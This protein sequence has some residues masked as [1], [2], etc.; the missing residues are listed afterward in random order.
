MCCG[1]L[2]IGAPRSSLRSV[3]LTTTA[4][5]IT[6]LATPALAQVTVTGN[7]TPD[8]WAPA[9][10]LVIGDTSFG[11]VTVENGST[12][13]SSSGSLGELADSDG[14]AIITG[15][16][17]RWDITNS[18]TVGNRGAATLQV[19][20]GGVVTTGDWMDI[21]Y[22][23]DSEAA[24]YVSGVDAFGNAST[25]QVGEE[26]SVGYY[27]G[28]SSAMLWVTDGGKVISSGGQIGYGASISTFGTGHV[29]V[30]GSDGGDN[31][32]TWEITGELAVGADVYGT[33]YLDITEGGKVVSGSGVLG[34][35]EFARGEVVVAGNDGAGNVSTWEI[36][37]N[38]TVG[39]DHVGKLD[40]TGG[41]KVTSNLVD[42]AS[43]SSGEGAITVTGHGGGAA[44]T[45][46]VNSQLRVGVKGEGQL[47]VE[48]GGRVESDFG[49]IAYETGSTGEVTISGSDGAGN[50]SIWQ[51]NNTL[52]IGRRG[53]GEVTVTEGGIIATWDVSAMVLGASLGG[54]GN[55]TLNIGAKS[56]AGA[57]A[58]GEVRTGELRFEN[59]DA[60]LVF[61]HTD[62]IEFST[63]MASGGVGNHTLKHEAGITTITG[64]NV[65][66]T[67]TTDVSGGTLIVGL[68]G[69]GSLVGSDVSVG[70]AGTLKGT[71]AL[72]RLTVQSGGLHA[73]GNSI[74]TQDVNGPYILQ[75]GAILEIEI[76][77]SSS[78]VVVVNGTVDI[79]GAI[80]KVLAAQDSY[81]FNTDYVIINNDGVDAVTG[82]FAT[83][84]SNYAFLVPTVVYDGG[85][86]NDVVLTITRNSVGLVN[87]AQTPNQRAVA[88]ALATGAATNPI[89]G[90]M[91]WL[92]AEQARQAFDALS[93]EVHASV[94]TVLTND[95]RFTRRI[96]LSRL[97][98]ASVGGAQGGTTQFA[99][100]GTN[101]D[102]PMALGMG[103][104]KSASGY[105]VPTYASP[106]VFWTQGFGSWGEFDGN[107][108]AAT[109][110]RTIGGFL[111]GADAA[112]GDGWRAGLALGYSHSSV[113]VGAR[114]SSADID[115]YHLSLYAGGMTGAVAL[116]A[117]G[118]WSWNNIDTG[119]TVAFPGFFQRV[120]SSYN[121]DVG[122]L[123]A[124]AALPLSAG[125]I[126][127][128]PFANIAYVHV[129][130]D[131]FTEQGGIAALN[132]SANN[133]TGF[134]TL[135]VRL[136]ASTMFGDARIVPRASFAWQYAFGDIDPVQAL[137]F[138]TGGPA[139]GISGV[140]LARNAALIDAGFDVLLAPDATLSLSY[141][142]E[143][144]SD[145]EDHG[146][147]GRVN[148]RF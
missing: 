137:A 19:L 85:D 62:D 104:G 148:W 109:A 114:L 81:A 54:V 110:N 97:Q 27:N 64:N 139:F 28:D 61:N 76:N 36:G 52:E 5:L 1:V 9:D 134:T 46:D 2:A 126:A 65:A 73:P 142:G 51:S 118:L 23:S 105:G 22:S 136:A 113:G 70:G 78:D 66:W 98:Q 63:R 131:R 33:G 125:S 132:G 87:V 133:D 94:G 8:P 56:G 17:S 13:A 88:G 24:V 143:L 106:L 11:Q 111:S 59:G 107:G 7:V 6:T 74:G 144:A 138:N 69:V 16:G 127:Y 21:N 117:G 122:Q 101:F 86:G 72:G 121:G 32:S 39:A 92:T 84:S 80:L 77:A 96:I 25:L 47:T 112:L 55:G 4:V 146:V 40:I 3:L 14:I 26:L 119:R 48:D 145:I 79:S 115:S 91:L 75:A 34:K 45:L 30:S 108:N 67:G 83:I 44:S 43:E 116:R 128:E 100:T 31:I 50:A 15:Y 129:S 29:T 58:A 140:P 41:G 18:L 37:G 49:Y 93:G 120:D 38:L 42:V 53:V 60:T 35:E 99:T 135:G 124:E 90:M 89:S 102:A 71:G 123:F 141:N 147:T 95:S 57:A 68:N 10:H 12:T 103:S 130:S 82:T 20:D